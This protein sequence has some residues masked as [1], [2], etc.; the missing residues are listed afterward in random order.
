MDLSGEDSLAL[1]TTPAFF[2]FL[3]SYPLSTPT[4]TV[5][6]PTP[7]TRHPTTNL[8]CQPTFPPRS[9]ATSS[10]KTARTRRS[11]P[12]K[13][14]RRRFVRSVDVG[15]LIWFSVFDSGPVSPRSGFKAI[16]GCGTCTKLETAMIARIVNGT[17]AR[18]A[19]CFDKICQGTIQGY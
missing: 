10:V 16:C 3:F 11:A 14:I 2:C 4:N 6:N 12:R 1:S 19:L 17:C 5:N 18:K 13:S 8:S 9:R 15:L 7:A